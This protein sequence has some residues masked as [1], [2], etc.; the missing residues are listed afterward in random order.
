MNKW[1]TAN[2]KEFVCRQ[3][4]TSKDVLPPGYYTTFNVRGETFFSSIQD[5]SDE[6]LRFGSDSKIEEAVSEIANFWKK[7]DFFNN[8]G[9][10]FRR[11]ILLYG[12]PGSGKSCAIKMIV[13]DLVKMGGIAI[14][15]SDVEAFESGMR[16]FRQIQPETPVVAIMEDIDD[17]LYEWETE[18]LNMMDG[19]GG[20]D[21]IVFL[22][23][24]NYL[25]NVPPRIRNRPS[26]FDRRIKIAYPAADVRKEYFIHLA[27]QAGVGHEYIEKFTEFSEGL[28]FAHMKEFFIS[29]MCFDVD[30]EE[31]AQRLKEMAQA[32]DDDESG[33]S[34]SP[35]EWET[36]PMIEHCDD[37]CS[38][39]E[40]A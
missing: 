25:K 21:N 15:M 12:P 33:E 5:M 37:V 32:P 20:F 4:M 27:S 13:Q 17:M 26:R 40:G 38:E 7:K 1:L 16:T 11:G 6:I 24:T 29:S 36:R 30:I 23:T 2:D 28:S 8:H 9:F 18:I 31:A 34:S 22:A 14:S 39:P 10:P 3:K 35:D 19:V